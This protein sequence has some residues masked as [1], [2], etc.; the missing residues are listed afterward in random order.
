MESIFVFAF[1]SHRLTT[2]NHKVVLARVKVGF[3]KH[4]HIY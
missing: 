2:T 3:N 1:H 4:S